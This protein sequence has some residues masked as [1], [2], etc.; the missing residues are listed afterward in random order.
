MRLPR[1]QSPASQ[2]QWRRAAAALLTS[3][4]LPHNDAIAGAIVATERLV[5]RIATTREALPLRTRVGSRSSREEPRLRLRLPTLHAPPRLIE[6]ERAITAAAPAPPVQRTTGLPWFHQ[7]GPEE[8]GPMQMRHRA[9]GDIKGAATTRTPILIER[10]PWQP[11][12]RATER[13]IKTLLWRRLQP[14]SGTLTVTTPRVKG[15]TRSLEIPGSNSS[16]WSLERSRGDR[17]SLLL[18]RR[19]LPEM[20]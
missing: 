20:H 17:V 2:L 10:F 15:A 5:L 6:R 9:P 11:L 14:E 1:R 13:H 16:S 19:P 4:P 7:R 12:R 18:G 8:I 3:D